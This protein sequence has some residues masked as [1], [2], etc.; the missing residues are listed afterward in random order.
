MMQRRHGRGLTIPR[1]LLENGEGVSYHLP[2]D[3]KQSYHP[4]HHHHHQP[5][6]Q[7]TESTR[8]ATL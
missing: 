5:E 4:S 1:D 2:N 3:H 8:H 6:H 7:I